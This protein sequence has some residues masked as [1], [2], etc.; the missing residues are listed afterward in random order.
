MA[1]YNCLPAFLVDNWQKPVQQPKASA[2]LMC[3]VLGKITD[4]WPY[5]R[6]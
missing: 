3:T 5:S 6:T 1:W 4:T 2:V